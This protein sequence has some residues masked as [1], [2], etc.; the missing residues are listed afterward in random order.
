MR[1]DCEQT[2]QESKMWTYVE[3]RNE[4][5]VLAWEKI[6]DA[7]ATIERI[8][9]AVCMLTNYGMK[10]GDTISVFESDQSPEQL[11]YVVRNFEEEYFEEKLRREGR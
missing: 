6:A 9:E 4:G 8:T 5:G 2:N 1:R 7:D 3:L 10:A 11:R